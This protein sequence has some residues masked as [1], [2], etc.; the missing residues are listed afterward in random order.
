MYFSK[1]RARDVTIKVKKKIKKVQYV[2][3]YF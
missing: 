3:F 1:K 2:Y